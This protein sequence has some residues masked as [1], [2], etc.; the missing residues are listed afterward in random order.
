MLVRLLPFEFQQLWRTPMHKMKTLLAAALLCL[1]CV[2]CSAQNDKLKIAVI[3]KSTAS[4]F[5]QSVQSG[6]NAASKE[7]NIDLSFEGP[8]N[9]EDYQAQIAMMEK[10]IKNQV[11]AIVLSSIDYTQLVAPVEKAVKE[12]IPVV[13]IDSDVDSDKVS[14]RITTNNF[15]A[16]KMAGSTVANS[17]LFKTIGIVNFDAHT[18][19]GQERENGFKEG[20]KK[21]QKVQGVYTINVQSNI[22]SATQGTKRLLEEHPD[23]TTLVTFNEWTTLGVGY[24]IKELNVMDQIMVVGF[25]NNPVSVGMLETGEVDA[26]VV[27]NPFVMG[28]LGVEQAQQIVTRKKHVEKITYTKTVVIDKENMFHEENQKIVF[29]FEKAK[30]K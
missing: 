5:F 14:T 28:Y 11:D 12:G 24:A 2:G 18:A 23:I 25:D 17:E 19:N 13:I 27:Q 4:Q 15:E 21:D 3:V 9:E 30:D 29:P 8:E 26:L 20:L 10:A 22:E 6:A 1:T 7:Y 16:G